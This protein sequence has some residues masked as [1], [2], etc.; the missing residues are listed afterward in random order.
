[1]SICHMYAGAHRGLK[2]A[3]DLESQAVVSYKPWVLKTKLVLWR[4]AGT[5]CC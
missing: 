3:L 2:E 5:T 4:A 1:M